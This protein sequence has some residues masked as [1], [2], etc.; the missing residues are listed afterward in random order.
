MILVGILYYAWISFP[1]ISGF[2]AKEMCT[3]VFVSGRDKEAVDT[4][5]FAGYPFSLG[6]NEL[7]LQDSSVT[8]SVLGMAR[9]KAIYRKGIGCTLIN[10]ITE[11]ELRSQVFSIPEA[12]SMATAT[13][14]WPSGDITVDA[15]PSAVDKSKLEGVVDKAF[16]EFLPG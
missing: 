3:C 14:P 2:D 10:D 7:N 16:T 8:T 4:S 11:K 15:I 1:I 9:K 5:E 13:M 12:P 6:R